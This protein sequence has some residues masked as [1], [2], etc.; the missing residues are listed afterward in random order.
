[1]VGL[2]VNDNNFTFDQER[3]KPGKFRKFLGLISEE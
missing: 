2:R 1:M 3:A